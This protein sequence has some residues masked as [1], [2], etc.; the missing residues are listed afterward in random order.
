MD[1]VVQKQKATGADWFKFVVLSLIGI[2]MFFIPIDIGGKSTIPL[3]HLVSFVKSAAPSLMPYYAL[4]V[5]I[6][7]AAYPFYSK[8]WNKDGV[9]TVFSIAKIVGLVVAIMAVTE[10]GLHGCLHQI[11]YHFCIINW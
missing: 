11:W 8:T 2:F 7:G 1:K 4:I 9:T 5:I 3:D 6:L 10:Q